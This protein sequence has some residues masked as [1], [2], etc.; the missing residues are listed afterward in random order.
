MIITGKCKFAMNIR[1]SLDLD[2]HLNIE[3]ETKIGLDYEGS[4]LFFNSQR[5]IT[6]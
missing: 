6:L 4:S 2:L 5:K 1:S 3:K